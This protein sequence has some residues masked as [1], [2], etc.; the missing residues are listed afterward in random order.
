MDT[1]FSFTITLLISMVAGSMMGYFNQY[2][3]NEGGPRTFALVTI[4]STL[5][6]L[7]SI[8]F[9]NNSDQPW[10]ADPARISAAVVAALSFLGTGLIWLS[11]EQRNNGLSSATNLWVAA[12][13]GMMLGSG[14]SFTNMLVFFMIILVFIVLN[15]VERRLNARKYK[16]LDNSSEEQK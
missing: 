15:F 13:F 6:T 3:G 1:L 12:L 16:V 10:L 14:F 5:V 11:E 8:Y 4:G 9:F 7:V 2:V